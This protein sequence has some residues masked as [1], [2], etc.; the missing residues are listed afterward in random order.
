MQRA[1]SHEEAA[2]PLQGRAR[3][4]GAAAQERLPKLHLPAAALR[5][6]WA[7]VGRAARPRAA[8][9]ALPDHSTWGRDREAGEGEGAA[10]AG[11]RRIS[12]TQA[13]SAAQLAE[14]RPRRGRGLGRGRQRGGGRAPVEAE[15]SGL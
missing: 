13:G 9:Q 10:P 8:S 5:G 14:V 12:A 2:G 3:H 6:G 1:D 7:T 4:R 11:R 15:F